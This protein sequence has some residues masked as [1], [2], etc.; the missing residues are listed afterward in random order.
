MAGLTTSG[1]IIK[2]LDDV[3][4]DL[5]DRFR[6][7][8]GADIRS[9]EKS[10]FGLLTGILARPV[11]E[12]WSG[13]QDVYDSF[14]P[15]AATGEALDNVARLVGVYREPATF[16]FATLTLGGTVGAVIPA[17]KVVRAASGREYVLTTNATIGGG[18][19]VTALFRADVAGAVNDPSG[20]VTTIVTPSAGWSSVTNALD[21]VG[22][23]DAE[24]DDA[25][26]LRRQRSLGIIGAATDQ[27]IAAKLEALATVSEARCISNRTLATVS[28]RPPKSFEALVWPSGGSVPMSGDDETL[29]ARTVFETMPAGIE[30][31]GSVEYDVTDTQGMTQRVRFSYA[32][33]VDVYATVTVLYEPGYAGDPA[34]IDAVVATGNASARIGGDVY[35]VD[36]ICAVAQVVGVRSVVV[37]IGR[38]LVP[39][40]AEL[41]RLTMTDTERP[42]FDSTRVT[43]VASPL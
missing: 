17:G 43:V 1:L 9:D 32:T 40:P 2:R 5:L 14:N 3:R 4:R 39:P 29:V 18:G 13:L 41:V 20:T 11:A 31:H 26:R 22:G 19:T 42:L 12:V 15:D 25:L 36:L 28:G 23:S 27:A 35:V 33:G 6:T 24:S 7:A 16:A 21:I 37:A 8:F 30:P 34:V 10:V 38:T